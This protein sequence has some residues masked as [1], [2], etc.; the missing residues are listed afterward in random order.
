[1]D[2]NTAT[3]LQDGLV[4][5]LTPLADKGQEGILRAVE[6]METEAPLVVK[7]LLRW[8]FAISLIWFLI[9]MCVAIVMASYLK[10]MW[11]WAIS[12]ADDTEGLSIIGGTVYTIVAGILISVGLSTTNWLQIL[13]APRLFLIEYIANM[14]K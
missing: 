5:W 8:H 13:V 7:E 14:V 3:S 6:L 12:V 1:M 10:K 4:A 11:A 2:P 9:P